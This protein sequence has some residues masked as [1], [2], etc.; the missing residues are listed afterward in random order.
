MEETSRCAS[1]AS[2]GP[3]GSPFPRRSRR[4]GARLVVPARIQGDGAPRP[5]PPDHRLPGADGDGRPRRDGLAPLRRGALGAGPQES[6][7]TATRWRA[8]S[9]AARATSS[10]GRRLPAPCSGPSG[11]ARTATSSSTVET[12]EEPLTIE[13]LSASPPAYP[14]EREG[15]LRRGLARAGPHPRGRLAHGAAVRARDL[16]GLPVLRAAPVRGRHAHPGPRLALHDGRRAADAQRHR[17]ARRLAHR[18]GPDPEPRPD[19]PA[20]VHPALLALVDRDGPRLLALPGRSGRSCAR[21][22]PASASVLGVLRATRQTADGSLGAAALVE[23]RGLGA[24]LAARASPPRGARRRRSA[25]LDL[26][27]LLAYG[28]AADLEQAVG[29]AAR[30]GER[31][32]IGRAPARDDPAALL[33]RAA[34]ASS[35]TRPRA[36]SSRST[37]TCSRSWPAWSRARRRARSW[38]AC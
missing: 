25:P 28:Y 18:R 21:C 35:R 38:T 8:R 7:A 6:R 17:P 5:G 33:G 23:F 29:S 32:E 24:G 13:D 14:F 36:R 4:R 31:R 1:R 16:H 22:C 37:R 12:A 20:A 9:S 27:L 26:Q 10:R 2:G 3:P 11:G 30:A 15:A 34:A 19:A